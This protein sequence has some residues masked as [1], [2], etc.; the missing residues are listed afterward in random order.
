MRYKLS[1]KRGKPNHEALLNELREV[2]KACEVLKTMKDSDNESDKLFYNDLRPW[3]LKLADM[4]GEAVALFEGKNPPAID[5]ENN[6]KYQFDILGGMGA[7]IS[8][9]VKKAEPSAQCL[10]EFIKWLREQ[11]T[12]K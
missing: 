4:T 2:N 10:P 6:T 5:Y 3:L 9:K 7:H 8:L 1:I 12:I 11:E